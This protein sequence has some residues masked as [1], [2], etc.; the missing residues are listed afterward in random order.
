MR[1]SVRRVLTSTRS[2]P[3]RLPGERSRRE[4]RCSLPWRSGSW[5]RRW[6]SGWGS[7]VR[8]CRTA[9]RRRNTGWANPSGL[10]GN[11]WFKKKTMK[12]W[13]KAAAAAHLSPRTAC[14]LEC[15]TPEW[16]GSPSNGQTR[17]P[18]SHR[19]ACTRGCTGGKLPKQ[20]MRS[21]VTSRTDQTQNRRPLTDLLT[22][23]GERP[24]QI[25]EGLIVYDV[26][27]ENVELVHRHR[28]LFEPKNGN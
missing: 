19:R 7:P 21:Y 8:R 20:T 11:T 12:K 26:P 6:C 27:V 23:L 24:A 15:R 25:R 4:T 16:P 18:S 28:F 13:L 14:V 3:R 10:S 1:T 17:S 9:R 2:P 5:S 22:Q